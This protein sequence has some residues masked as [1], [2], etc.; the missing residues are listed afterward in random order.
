VVAIVSSGGDE[1]LSVGSVPESGESVAPGGESKGEVWPVTIS[2]AVLPA[3]PDDGADPAIGQV[4]P[5][6]SGYTFDGSA[7]DIDWS[8]GPTMVVVLAHWCPH[9]NDELPELVAWKASGEVPPELQVVGITTNTNAQAPNYPPSQWIED[10][11]W[12]W[13]VMADD[14]NSDAA[15]A[16][17]VSS[18]PFTAIVGTD[19]K[20]LARWAGELGQAG[21]ADRVAEALA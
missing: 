13:P 7:V 2:G 18:F 14:E 8:K 1:D 12:T 15:I 5:T 4:A 20:V 9:C 6:I 10:K 3:L 16:L 17:G 21:I 19:G 11:G